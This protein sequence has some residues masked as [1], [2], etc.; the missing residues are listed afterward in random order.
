[1]QKEH[2]SPETTERQAPLRAHACWRMDDLTDEDRIGLALF[3]FRALAI[4][5]GTDDREIDAHFTEAVLMALVE[6]A[7]VIMG[8]PEGFYF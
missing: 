1:M 5:I 6:R 7:E 8:F 3:P 4:L 2:V